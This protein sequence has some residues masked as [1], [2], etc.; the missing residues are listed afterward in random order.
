MSQ[1]LNKLI[2]EEIA[3]IP[4]QDAKANNVQN[5]RTYDQYYIYKLKDAKA[6]AAKSVGKSQ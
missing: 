3:K 5:G 1:K 4:E 2:R 6:F